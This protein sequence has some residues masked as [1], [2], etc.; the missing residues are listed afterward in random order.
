MLTHILLIT[1][2][3]AG[4]ILGTLL[5]FL[6]GSHDSLAVVLSW[7]SRIFGVVGL[8]LVPVGALWVASGYWRRLAG[9][10]YAIAIAALIA[11]SLIWVF[12]SL[13]ALI[14]GEVVIGLGGLAVWIYAVA[15]VLPPLK[16]S[17][18]AAPRATSPAAF[19]L[20]IVPIAVG[21]VQMAVVAPAIES[22]RSRAIRNSAPLIADIEQYRA[23]NGRYPESLLSLWP[24]YQPGVIGI[25]E[26]HYEPS[27]EAYN[28]FFEQT[29]LSFGTREIVMYN[30]RDQQV[31]TSHKFDR[32]QL[33]AHALA[34]EQ[35][36]GHYA[37]HDAPHPHWK[38]FWFD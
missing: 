26:Y 9:K 5:P 14:T 16:R 19:Y 38:Y 29:A 35:T 4:I 17:R 18:T 21:L 7:M 15:R 37:V 24:D 13:A 22:S 6:P 30:P 27:G 23:A 31:M 20:L 32:L 11:S 33:T 34:I 10:Q 8:L 3:T 2:I 1:A 28:L 12:A 36:R 25:K